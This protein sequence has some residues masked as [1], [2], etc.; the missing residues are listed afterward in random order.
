MKRMTDEE[1]NEIIE[2]NAYYNQMSYE[3]KIDHATAKILEWTEICADAGKNYA[4]SVGGLDSIVL[5]IFVRSILGDCDGISVSSLEDPSIQKIHRDLG[6][7]PI[8][9]DMNFHQVLNTYG[10][11]VLSKQL[12]GKIEHLQIP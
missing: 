12:A 11:P 10:F 4:V 7:I 8:K 1:K 6:V 5:L 2:R 9:P 3:D